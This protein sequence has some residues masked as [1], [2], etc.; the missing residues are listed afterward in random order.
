MTPIGQLRPIPGRRNCSRRQVPCSG[1]ASFPWRSTC[2]SL[3]ATTIRRCGRRT[4][5]RSSVTCSSGSTGGATCTSRRA[6]PSTRSTTRDPRS[7]RARSWWW[8]PWGPSGA[9]FRPRFPAS[10]GCPPGSPSRASS[11]PAC[12]PCAR[13]RT[14][15]RRICAHS[16]RGYRRPTRSARSRS[17]VLVDDSDFC[18]RSLDNFLWVTFTRSNPAA[19]IDGI[20]ASTAQKHWGCAGSLV[21]DARAKQHHAPPLVEDPAVTARVDKLFAKGGPL[22]GLE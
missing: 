15:R 19:D 18:A 14:E 6:R 9:S 3:T 17:C 10:C 20:A 8:R 1:K 11:C 16:A 5:P 22:A 7:T 13:P 12:S 2:S 4:S 21:I